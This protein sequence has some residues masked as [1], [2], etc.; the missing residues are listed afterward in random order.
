MPLAPTKNGAPR[1]AVVAPH[2][3]SP[4]PPSAASTAASKAGSSTHDIDTARDHFVVERAPMRDAPMR[5]HA[6]LL[7]PEGL[8]SEAVVDVVRRADGVAIT[9]GVVLPAAPLERVTFDVHVSALDLARYDNDAVTIDWQR[10]CSVG[11]DGV[12]R[13]LLSGSEL[14]PSDA[15]SW[16]I[17]LSGIRTLPPDGC[18]VGG[19]P[20]TLHFLPDAPFRLRTG[21]SFLRITSPA[22]AAALLRRGALID[23]TALDAAPAP[24]A[25]KQTMGC[26][27]LQVGNTIVQLPTEDGTVPEPVLAFYTKT[28]EPWLRT[29]L[30]KR[31]LAGRELNDAQAVAAA[32]RELQRGLTSSS[33]YAAMPPDALRLIGSWFQAATGSA[34]HTHDSATLARAAA[35][36]TQW[37]APRL[38]S[39]APVRLFIAGAGAHFTSLPS[40]AAAVAPHAVQPMPKAQGLTLNAHDK[41]AAD[42]TLADPAHVE[43]YVNS[44]HDVGQLRELVFHELWHCIE[45]VFLHDDEKR[46]LRLAHAAACK[47]ERGFPRPYS[48]QAHEFGTTCTELYV[49]ENPVDRAFLQAEHPDVFALLERHLGAV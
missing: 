43:V 37:S 9:V 2:H 26:T 21:Q 31:T 4:P 44:T 17:G 3:T 7:L 6:Q 27:A 28:L 49:S 48:A 33:A 23:M 15:A 47:G 25:A 40:L 32:A 10:V 24:V 46:T 12:R 39:Q 35:L 14:S 29:H 38:A 18:V 16:T 20:P 8:R 22:V 1:D 11:A 19:S 42:G 45:E 41:F 34:L 30:N 13:S 5:A 36:A